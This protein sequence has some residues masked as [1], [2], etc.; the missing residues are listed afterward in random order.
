M[1]EHGPTHGRF[2]RAN[3]WFY[4]LLVAISLGLF[5]AALSW[6][7]WEPFCVLAGMT[8]GCALRDL[9]WLRRGRREWP[10]N[11]RVIDW[12]KVQRMANGD[13]VP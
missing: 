8:V 13:A 4:L 12:D 2:V 5:A 9:G 11:E 10:T 7:Q 1:R 3:L 6:H